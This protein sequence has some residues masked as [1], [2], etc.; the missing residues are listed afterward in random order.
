MNKVK[1]IMVAIDFS[2]HSVAAAQYAAGLA[3]DVDAA[4]LLTNVVN[5]RDVDHM[6]IAVKRVAIFS[7][8]K[9][10]E[11]QIEH[12]K[13]LFEDLEKKLNLDN[14]NVQTSVRIGVPFREILLEI[15]V[16]EPDLLVMGRKG[17]S[18]LAD[19]VIGSCAQKLFRRCSIPL[20][21]I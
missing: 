4:L 11:E 12:R 21:T 15:K 3:S 16:N 5:Q 14:L 7:V 10:I 9:Y 20:L 18:E 6:E 1:K 19:I 17:R 13:K 2:E 8:E